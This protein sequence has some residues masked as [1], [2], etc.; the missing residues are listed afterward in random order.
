[1][2]R[3][4]LVSLLTVLALAFTLGDVRSSPRARAVT[5]DPPH[6]RRR[7]HRVQEPAGEEPER[8]PVR[9]RGG[10]DRGR[11]LRQGAA[12]RRHPVRGRHLSR[13][14][15]RTS[16][17][18]SATSSRPRR[19]R[20]AITSTAIPARRGTSATSAP[21]APGELLLLRPRGVARRLARLDDLRRGGCGRAF[22]G[23][24][25]IRGS[26]HDL[27]NSD[28]L[29]TLAFWH[30]PRWDWLKYQN[31]DWTED[32]EL[33]TVEAALGP[34]VRARCGPRAHRSQPQLLA[35]E[36]GRSARS[37]RPRPRSDPVRGRAPAAG[38]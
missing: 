18:T 31:A 10:R 14:S 26:R 8:L 19:P 23:R 28:A 30:H 34:A 29:C 38:T 4:A 16:T 27:E 5:R 24:L 32:Y 33:L 22:R 11:R 7:R 25:S 35:L 15:S 37:I 6:R 1:M 17:C 13:T 3:T 36:A 9:R 21:L 20:P 12:P 2:R